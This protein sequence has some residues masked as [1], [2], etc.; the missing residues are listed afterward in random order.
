MHS[1]ISTCSDVF[2]SYHEVL[3]KLRKELVDLHDSTQDHIVNEAIIQ[4]SRLIE[5]IVYIKTYICPEIPERYGAIE[6][7]TAS[8]SKLRKAIYMLEEL[9]RKREKVSK[10]EV[11]TELTRILGDEKRAKRLIRRLIREGELYEPEE[12]FLAKI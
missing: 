5:N 2:N 8:E 4:V 10:D 12:G 11:L 6:E 9:F 1:S 3:S 7:S